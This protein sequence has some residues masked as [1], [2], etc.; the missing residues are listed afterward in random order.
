MEILG[1]SAAKIILILIIAIVIFGPDKVP[2]M[3]RTVGKTIRDV[4]RHASS[5]VG[6]HIPV[7]NLT[8]FWT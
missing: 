6:V 7:V 1:F 2:E 4:R 3:A 5:Q 8:V